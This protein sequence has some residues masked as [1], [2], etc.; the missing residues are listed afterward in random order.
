MSRIPKRL[1]APPGSPKGAFWLRQPANDIDRW[2]WLGES[3]VVYHLVQGE[4]LQYCGQIMVDGVVM[5]YVDARQRYPEPPKQLS[6]WQE[7]IEGI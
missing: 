7:S 1:P 2:A 3:H 5:S 6:L 4:R